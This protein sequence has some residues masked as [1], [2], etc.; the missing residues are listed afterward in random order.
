MKEKL[1][2]WRNLG[3]EKDTLLSFKNR[4]AYDNL[5]IL[6]AEAIVLGALCFVSS[7]LMISAGY[8]SI[9]H[10]ALLFTAFLCFIIFFMA[11]ELRQNGSGN[12]SKSVDVLI[13]AFQVVFYSMSA[14]IGIYNDSNYAALFVGAVILAQVSFDLFPLQNFVMTLLAV[15]IYIIFSFFY[16]SPEILYY[17]S[18][19]I[20]SC[21]I[22]GNI[23]SWKKARVKYEHEE[24]VELIERNNSQLYR[25][26][27]TDP[28]TGLLNRRNAFEKL[29]I[30][31]AQ[32][33]VAGK[34]IVVMILDLDNFKKF[35][36]TY[37]HPA[38][39]KLLENLG[40]VLLDIQVRY[41]ISISRIGGEE[42]MVFFMPS[43]QKDTAVIAAEICEKTRKIDHPER[44]KGMHST[45]SIGVYQSVAEKDDTA[46]KVYSK[47]DHALY[48]AKRNGRDRVEYYDVS[49]E[50]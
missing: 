35:N 10:V 23:I 37:G 9:K 18:L 7:V 1:K 27:L 28:L 31:T 14:F 33:S 39:D 21:A 48:D 24:S 22:L 17:D 32:A 19:N 8:S 2:S 38:G 41:G 5:R 30:M 34:E 15:G 11:G 25:T 45:I 40:T 16:K 49:V 20:L 47:A 12:L 50:K 29:E 4:V 42:F 6:H 44:E 43:K 13:V 46:S 36:D 26:S 3:L